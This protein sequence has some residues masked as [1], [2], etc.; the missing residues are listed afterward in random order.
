MLVKAKVTIFF[1]VLYKNSL[2]SELK[3]FL[4][5]LLLRKGAH[6]EYFCPC[7]KSLC[8]KH[9]MLWKGAHEANICLSFGWIAPV[10]TDQMAVTDPLGEAVAF[11]SSCINI[12]M[13]AQI[14]GNAVFQLSLSHLQ[15]LFVAWRTTLLLFPVSRRSQDTRMM[16]GISSDDPPSPP[17]HH[18]PQI[19]RDWTLA[20]DAPSVVTPM[21]RS[22]M[23]QF[24]GL[25]QVKDRQDG[26]TDRHIDERINRRT[27]RRINRRTDKRTDRQTDG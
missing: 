3:N 14:C 26:R 12:P 22:E 8:T 23:T 20:V 4:H 7:R 27:D 10:W 1:A 25:M 19:Y 15:R 18:Q 24:L 2:S 9:F 16:D 21:P 6:E 13:L 17:L 5:Y 11:R